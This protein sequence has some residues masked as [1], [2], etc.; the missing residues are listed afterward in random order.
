MGDVPSLTSL[1][2]KA[3]SLAAS[4]T[5]GG[6]DDLQDV[7]DLPSDLFD[8]LLMHLSPLAMEKLQAALCC[9]DM[10]G[11]DTIGTT[12]EN[13]RGRYDELSRTWEALFKVRWPENDQKM[14]RIRLIEV[15]AFVGSHEDKERI[16]WHQRYWESH[17]QE[18][19][20]EASEKALL[21]SFDGC[22]KE[23]GISNALLDSIGCCKDKH[24]VCAK[25]SYH[26]QHFGI[27][28]RRLRLQN[29]LFVAGTSEMLKSC[30]LQDVI[31]RNIKSE[32]HV[33]E[34]C[35]ILSQN[36]DVLSSLNLVHCRFSS[37]GFKGLF[38][39]LYPSGGR[40]HG[41]QCL[42]IT[43]SSVF[44]ANQADAYSSF[45][46]FLSSGRSLRAVKLCDVG[47]GPRIANLVFDALHISSSLLTSLDISDDNL[48]GWLSKIPRESNTFT[49]STLSSDSVGGLT[50]LSVLNL[51]GNN[52][53]EDDAEDLKFALLRMPRLKQLDISDNPLTDAGL[54][55]LIPYF[56]KSIDGPDPLSDIRLENCGLS[57]SAVVQF[58]DSIQSLRM[59][60]HSLSLADNN[61]GSC[62][63]VP[64]ARFLEP[65]RLRRLN[66]EDV[67]L[68]PLGFQELE[69]GLPDHVDLVWVNISKNRGR[70]KAAEFLAKLFPS[71]PELAAVNAGFNFMPADSL[72][73]IGDAL[74]RFPGKLQRVDL[75]GNA[76]LRAPSPPSVLSDIRFRGK[77]VLILPSSPSTAAYDDDP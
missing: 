10:D 72:R 9:G 77:P 61:L 20:D 40:I 54:R 60:L 16:D 33:D 67:G 48:A 49:P 17:L 27:Y 64:L 2:M 12:E 42:S 62:V 22:I 65:S 6:F 70:M 13:K 29:V 73:V 55:S 34:M 51:R 32:A 4:G 8:A 31:I 36:K 38:S 52:L 7:F 5:D 15:P 35:K 14:P 44:A 3:I 68:G 63:G 75:T 69:R 59:P 53:G 41:I 74:Y 19:L 25:L 66:I 30:Q 45:L 47:M 76:N 56:L 46:E 26:C 58:L 37:I 39:S 1:C 21:P 11:S 43:S 50:S 28:A 24:N 57:S 18:C 23:I 71:A